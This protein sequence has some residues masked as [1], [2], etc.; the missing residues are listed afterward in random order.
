MPDEKDKAKE[1]MVDK[2]SSLTKTQQAQHIPLKKK[3]M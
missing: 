2:H 3:M 1:K